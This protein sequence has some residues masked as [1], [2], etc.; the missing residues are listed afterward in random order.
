MTIER[1]ETVS[2]YVLI[3]FTTLVSIIF[4][5]IGWTTNQTLDSINRRIGYVS[6]NLQD[7]KALV[8]QGSNS[9]T[10]HE[11]EIEILKTQIETLEKEIQKNHKE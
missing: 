2:K 1:K 8:A 3:I 7:L 5:L 10:Q 4:A 11:T 9:I 6:E